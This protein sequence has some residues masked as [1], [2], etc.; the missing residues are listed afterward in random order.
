MAFLDYRFPVFPEVQEEKPRISVPL[1]YNDLLGDRVADIR[2]LD[3]GLFSD[4]RTL[5]NEHLEIEFDFPNIGQNEIQVPAKATAS[6]TYRLTK[7]VLDRNASSM[8]GDG[9][10]QGLYN[11]EPFVYSMVRNIEV[12]EPAP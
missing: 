9:K 4:E 1:A 7:V 12:D 6:T 5:E 3:S 10:M 8:G 11:E 2:I